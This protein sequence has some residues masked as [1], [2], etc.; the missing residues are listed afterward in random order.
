MS[1]RIGFIHDKHSNVVVQDSL[2]SEDI[3]GILLEDKEHIVFLPYDVV[4]VDTHRTLEIGVQAYKNDVDMNS[5]YM[6]RINSELIQSHVDAY[7]SDLAN[8]ISCDDT[9]YVFHESKF[10]PE[11]REYPL[12]Y[13]KVDDYIIGLSEEN[14]ELEMISFIEKII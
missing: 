1:D 5:F 4:L 6:A 10:E 7:M 13:Y 11:M 9:V 8:G 12:I 14:E 2:I 3:W